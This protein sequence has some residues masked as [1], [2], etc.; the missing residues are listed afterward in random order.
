[1]NGAATRR[2]FAEATGR[3]IEYSAGLRITIRHYGKDTHAV[4]NASRGGDTGENCAQV[5]VRSNAPID[6]S[7]TPRS[8]YV[9]DLLAGGLA[10]AA[11]I[12]RERREQREQK[13]RLDDLKR[14]NAEL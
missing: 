3:G 2:I 1:M 8:N 5:R 13:I 4:G 10:E 7:T 6:E 9:T 14:R 12:A 11:R